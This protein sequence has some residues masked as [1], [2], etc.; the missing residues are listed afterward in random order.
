[1]LVSGMTLAE[2]QEIFAMRKQIILLLGLMLIGTLRL[3]AGIEASKGNWV[4]LS[5]LKDHESSENDH[6]FT[7]ATM[8]LGKVSS[9][10]HG[11]MADG[12]NTVPFVRSFFE[13]VEGQPGMV[14]GEATCSAVT[15]DGKTKPQKISFS[16][17]PRE[18]AGGIS[19]ES[20]SVS[21]S[22][23][24]FDKLVPRNTEVFR[25]IG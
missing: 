14:V 1:M 15:E 10:F 6:G 24:P 9:V 13:G 16:D 25:I 5:L 7:L 4:Y 12:S 8:S 2:I 23:L 18:N 20:H 21:Q 19:L 11:G 3:A 22:S 17:C